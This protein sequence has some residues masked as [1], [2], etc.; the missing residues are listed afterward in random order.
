LLYNICIN[1]LIALLPVAAGNSTWIASKDYD[2]LFVTK[3]RYLGSG[4][5]E[6]EIPRSLLLI[7]SAMRI[8]LT[9]IIIEYRK[10]TSDGNFIT[11]SEPKGSGDGELLLPLGIDIDSSNNIYVIDQGT[12]SVVEFTSNGI[13]LVPL[14]KP[15]E[16]GQD[17]KSVLED[18]EINQSGNIYTTDRGEHKINK[19]TKSQIKS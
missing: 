17:G 18:V 16:N 3:S 4:N 9:L 15:E 12:R 11:K 19:Y 14:L 7:S 8:S 5:G 6:F 13:F 2:Y 10:F 1:F